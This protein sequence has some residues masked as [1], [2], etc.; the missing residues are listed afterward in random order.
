MAIRS[1][2]SAPL[3]SLLRQVGY[4]HRHGIVHR[5]LKLENWLMQNKGETSD[6]KLIDFGLSKHFADDHYLSQAV[7]STYYVAPGKCPGEVQMANVTRL[8]LSNRAIIDVARTV[9][10]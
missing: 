2:T 6:I 5:D 10:G 3:C 4:M 8:Y 1:S 9:L 7:G